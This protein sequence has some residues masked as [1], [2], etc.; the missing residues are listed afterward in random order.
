MQINSLN[1]FIRYFFVYSYMPNTFRLTEFMNE[2]V[3]I[4][5]YNFMDILFINTAEQCSACY[6][7]MFISLDIIIEFFLSFYI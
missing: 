7:A 1:N 6:L 2:F 4:F 3:C 5:C